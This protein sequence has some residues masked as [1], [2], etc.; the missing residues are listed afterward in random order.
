MRWGLACCLGVFAGLAI[1]PTS[2]RADILGG[3]LRGVGGLF[4]GTH[5]GPRAHHHRHPVRRESGMSPSPVRVPPQFNGWL[6]ARYWPRAYQDTFGYIVSGPDEANAFWRHN[7]D[8]IY[9]G[10]FVPAMAS[11]VISDRSLDVQSA[12]ADD[13][14]QVFLLESIERTLRP[15]AAQ[16]GLTEAQRAGLEAVRGALVQASERLRTSCPASLTV[17]GPTARLESMWN[18]LRALRQAVGLIRAPLKAFY[19]SLS[20]EQK[21]RLNAPSEPT[22]MHRRSEA[23]GLQV[24]AES[25]AK[26]HEWPGQRIEEAV[27]P[28]AQQRARLSTL[29]ATTSQLSALLAPSC[30]PRVVVTPTGRL[31]AVV[32]RL[33]SMIY[34]VTLERAALNDFY[35][36]LNDAQKAKFAADIGQ[37]PRTLDHRLPP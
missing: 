14:N 12:C 1:L 8:D 24:C 23:L 28:S 19:D 32:N 3:L 16:G 26:V 13:H 34:A 31:E 20:D 9:D 37:P 25:G 30:P 11:T 10:V 6:G 21:A 7:G 22:A 36:A 35:A 33:D 15:A 27:R 5:G 2:T 18:R 29:A 4:G 17:P